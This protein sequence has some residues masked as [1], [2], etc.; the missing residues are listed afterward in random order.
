MNIRL[1][2]EPKNL[3]PLEILEE[4]LSFYI[5]NRKNGVSMMCNGTVL[6]TQ[7]TENYREDAK[8]LMEHAAFMT[9]FKVI[10][11]SLGGFFVEFKDPVTVFVGQEEFYSQ[12]ES[13][14]E[15]MKDL[16]FPE[17]V[18]FGG[19]DENKQRDLLVGLYARGK[20]QYDAYNFCFYKRL[21]PST[22]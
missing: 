13:I 15:R 1:G 18:L 2:W 9:D 10:E 17:E 11:L 5:K 3:A 4:R 14:R 20:L 21:E 12:K 22:E 7:S 8:F 19:N 16:L 6:F